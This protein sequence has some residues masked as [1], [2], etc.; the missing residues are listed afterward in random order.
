MSYIELTRLLKQNINFGWIG[1]SRV[2]GG[3]QT[4]KDFLK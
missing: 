2:D 1:E 4:T 3:E